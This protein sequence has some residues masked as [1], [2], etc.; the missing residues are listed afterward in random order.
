MEHTQ[1]AAYHV[2]MLERDSVR[3]SS[4]RYSQAFGVQTP[5]PPPEAGTLHNFVTVFSSPVN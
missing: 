4:A 2:G 5:T 1:L 3:V